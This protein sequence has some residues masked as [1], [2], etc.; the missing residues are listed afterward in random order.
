MSPEDSIQTQL[1]LNADIIMAFDECTD[2]PSSQDEA[3]NSMNLTI[4]GQK[5]QLITF[6]NIKTDIYYSE[7]FREGC[8]KI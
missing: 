1:T 6:K 2:Y 5:D 8:T 7:L 3:E 4:D